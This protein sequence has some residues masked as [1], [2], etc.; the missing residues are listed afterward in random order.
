MNLSDA[1]NSHHFIAAIVDLCGS[2]VAVPHHE[3][4]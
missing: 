4:Q 2:D 1:V 3:A